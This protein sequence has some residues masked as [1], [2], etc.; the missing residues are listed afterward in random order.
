MV[1]SKYRRRNNA[2][3]ANRYRP[4]RLLW[5]RQGVARRRGVVVSPW[6]GGLETKGTALALR[7]QCPQ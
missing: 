1:P 5:V 6:K 3:E 7:T 2:S 4:F